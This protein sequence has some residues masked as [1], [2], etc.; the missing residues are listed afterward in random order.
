MN[1]QDNK[2]AAMSIEK[3]ASGALLG[4]LGQ[5]GSAHSPGRAVGSA[6]V[7]ERVEAVLTHQ[8]SSTHAVASAH[9]ASPTHQGAATATTESDAGPPALTHSPA[10]AAQMVYMDL[11]EAISSE[12][13]FGRSMLG[14]TNFSQV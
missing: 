4:G 11:R 3:F 8:A 7:R 10:T 5:H 12:S 13:R 6:D 1:A 9:N 2:K 14:W